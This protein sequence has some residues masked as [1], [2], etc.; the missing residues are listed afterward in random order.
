MRAL[1]VNEWSFVAGGDD[2]PMEEVVLTGK[3]CKDAWS[4]M[5]MEELERFLENSYTHPPMGGGG[6]GMIIDERL[7]QETVSVSEIL[8]AAAALAALVAMIYGI[9]ALAA[10]AAGTVAAAYAYG[11]LSA[12]LA[13]MAAWQAMLEP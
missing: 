3:R 12:V 4:C 1:T 13:L 6:D 7:N 8:A 5:S 2:E 9:P 11:G 10:G